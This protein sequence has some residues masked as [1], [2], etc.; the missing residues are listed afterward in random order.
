MK[1]DWVAMACCLAI[2]LA[3]WILIMIFAAE[4]VVAL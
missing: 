2:V 1:H 3:I 4:K